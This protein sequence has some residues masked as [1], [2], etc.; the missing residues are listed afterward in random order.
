MADISVVV[1]KLHGFETADD[2][3]EY[4]REYG[5]QAFP[6][7]ARSCAISQFVEMETGAAGN[8][9]TTTR[10]IS[11]QETVVENLEDGEEYTYE[12]D[13]WSMTH[14]HAM[15]EFVRNFDSGRYPFLV[16]NGY[17]FDPNYD[18]MDMIYYCSCDKCV[19]S[20]Y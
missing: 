14:S 7:E 15:V 3:A 11:L 2:I 4:F 17:E 1:E 13:V 9:I 8:I 16:V 5:I 18:E 12:Q 19:E 20:R 6:Q 10:E